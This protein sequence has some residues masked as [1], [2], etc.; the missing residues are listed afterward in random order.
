[1]ASQGQKNDSIK[2]KSEWEKETEAKATKHKP[3]IAAWATA[4]K[5]T[6]IG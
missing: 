3:N 6:K 1:M 5:K 4:D 2:T